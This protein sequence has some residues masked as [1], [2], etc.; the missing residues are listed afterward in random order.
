MHKFLLTVAFVFAAFAAQA[1]TRSW[2][3]DFVW[4]AKESHYETGAYATHQTMKISRVDDGSI[5]VSQVVTL[6]DGKT[7]DW[8]IDSPLD[9]TMRHAST[10][11]SFAFKRLSPDAIH[12]RYV[13][14]DGQQG[15]ETF[16]MENNKIVI[17]GATIRD[18]KKL[19]YVEVW[20]R[21]ETKK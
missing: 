14:D 15:E 19:P 11:M 13:M 10:W 17:R 20:D 21:V 8:N 7:F 3:G 6:K 4:N 2:V 18:G 1:D 16:T 5:A 9:D 12:N